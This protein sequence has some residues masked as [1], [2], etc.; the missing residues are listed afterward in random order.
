MKRFIKAIAIA[1]IPLGTLTACDPPIPLAVLVAE[2]EKVVSCE[3]GELSVAFDD[4]FADL[5]LSWQQT[6]EPA[7]A[8]MK[9]NQ[10]LIGE[11]AD[12]YISATLAPRCE[13][14]ARVPVAVDAAVVTFYLDEAFT[15][16]LS[17]STIDGILSGT[18]TSWDDPAIL[19]DN[20]DMTPISL[21]I[22][23]VPT[24][25]SA[26]IN[27]MEAWSSRLSGEEVVFDALVADDAANLLDVA[28]TMT[29]G[30][31]ALLPYSVAAVSGSTFANVLA[32][33]DPIMDA[34]LPEFATM[35]AG[36]TQFEKV[37]SDLGYELA[38][39]PELE[40]QPEDGSLQ[41][42]PPYQAV[43]PVMMDLCGEDTTL[44][45]T[46]ARYF[47]RLDAQGIVATSTVLGLTEYLRIESAAVVSEGLVLPTPATIEE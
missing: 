7:C 21:P 11:E 26:L 37:S 23:V 43:V 17:G 33:P 38:L 42:S 27:S 4:G 41:A 13:A 19:S 15:M 3:T 31:V 29:N 16:N 2:A 14:F 10:V 39:N 45:R 44:K 20:P 5:G 12:L 35:Y 40:P 24:S 32:G 8:D 22:N 46:L 1:A 25:S 47:L 18:I 9:F 36:K 34:V 6:L 28:F 30:D